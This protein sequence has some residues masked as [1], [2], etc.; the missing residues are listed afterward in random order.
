MRAIRHFLTTTYRATYYYRL[1]GTILGRSVSR[2]DSA[3]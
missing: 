2:G 1:L 3:R